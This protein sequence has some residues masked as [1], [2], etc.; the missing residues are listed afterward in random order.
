MA[1]ISKIGT[2]GVVGRETEEARL[3]AD[4]EAA[5]P[6]VPEGYE[7]RVRKAIL[8]YEN[9]DEQHPFGWKREDCYLAMGLKKSAFFLYRKQAA[10]EALVVPKEQPKAG[11]QRLLSEEATQELYDYVQEKSLDL[12]AVE[13]G[14]IFLQLVVKKIQSEG[15]NQ[16]AEI[17]PS[18]SYMKMLVRLFTVVDSPVAKNAGRLKQFE[19]VRNSLSLCAAVHSHTQRDLSLDMWCSFDDVSVY[20]EAGRKPKV[21]TT[22]KA[23]KMLSARNLNVSYEGEENQKRMITFNCMIAADGSL[24]SRVVK[25]ADRCFTKHTKVPG[26]YEFGDGRKKLHVIL[27]HP[28]LPDTVL[29]TALFKR[30]LV[31][32]ALAH[33]KRMEDALELELTEIQVKSQESSQLSAASACS[34]NP[35]ADR[36][37]PHLDDIAPALVESDDEEDDREKQ[38]QPEEEQLRN[39]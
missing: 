7:D 4:R 9:Y 14:P 32:A 28:S 15:T 18:K 25:I 20:L 29:Y 22:K 16:L 6:A 19:N 8:L 37:I 10:E 17:I 36:A 13:T 31:P 1:H 24:L 12:K 26:L 2:R 27:A 38:E 11:R 35:E 39:E 3:A 33:R 30:I 5:F 21:L 34:R 23:Q